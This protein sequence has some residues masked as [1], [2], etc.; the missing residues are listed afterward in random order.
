M[1]K[2]TVHTAQTHVQHEQFRLHTGHDRSL[3]DDV[4]RFPPPT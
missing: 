1:M 4:V 2:G 3:D